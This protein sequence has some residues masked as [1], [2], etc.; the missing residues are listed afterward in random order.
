MALVGIIKEALA[1]GGSP[2]ASPRIP[3]TSSS[4]RSRAG[5]LLQSGPTTA[6]HRLVVSFPP[7]D[8]V[9]A[10]AASCP[11]LDCVTDFAFSAHQLVSFQLQ[12]VFSCYFKLVRFALGLCLCVN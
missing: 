2:Q 4:N 8:A 7:R 12:L 5:W 9:L 10:V 6:Y 1:D 11:C 3:I